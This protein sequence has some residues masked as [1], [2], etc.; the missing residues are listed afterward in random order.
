MK[1]DSWTNSCE[2]SGVHRDK[3]QA[4]NSFWTDDSCLPVDS[5]NYLPVWNLDLVL[6]SQ[7]WLIE[8]DDFF[9]AFHYH[10]E[11]IDVV[12]E[13]ILVDSTDE[14]LYLT[15]V[16]WYWFERSSILNVRVDRFTR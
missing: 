14:F 5:Y 7:V 3:T 9:T 12:P 16:E 6:V 10:P 11:M 13:V 1:L 4:T 2:M 8:N 15:A